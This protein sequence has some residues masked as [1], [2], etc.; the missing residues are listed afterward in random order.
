MKRI[1]IVD[2]AL[3]MRKYLADIITSCGYEV[4]GE[5]EDG[6]DAV[7]KYQE[8]KPDLVTMDITMPLMDGIEA[9][10]KILSIDPDAKIIMCTAIDEQDRMIEAIQLGALEYFIKPFDK[11]RI[12]D[13]L[14]LIFRTM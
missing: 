14:K 6:Q 7:R 12:A 4:A 13:M 9:L 8:L 2:D 3:F 1:L 11:I 10:A 5:A